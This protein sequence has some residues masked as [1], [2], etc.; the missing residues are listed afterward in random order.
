MKY[1]LPTEAQWEYACRAG[2]KT[3]FCFGNAS[4]DLCRYGN[5]CDK[6]FQEKNKPGWATDSADKVW[7]D[8][9]EK[10]AP[11]GSFRPNAWDLY[12]MHGNVWEWC[13]D[14]FSILLQS[15]SDPLAR[16]GDSSRAIQKGGAFEYALKYCRSATRG[17]S[18]KN[19]KS[20]TS[21]FRVAL[22]EE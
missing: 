4:S 21:G 6:S 2:T 14:N 15:G 17:R 7:N 3:R 22:V 9:Y 1:T 16:G 5:F 13:A 18:K 12:D 8:G 10:A 19:S 20:V 11:V